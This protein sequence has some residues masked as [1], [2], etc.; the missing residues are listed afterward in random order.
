MRCELERGVE[1]HLE[2]GE[3]AIVDADEVG[4]GRDRNIEFA[5]IVHFDQRGKPPAR[6]AGAEIANLL[7]AQD[8]GDEQDGIG[9]VR[10]GF[11]DLRFGDGEVLAQDR[12]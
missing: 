7:F 6:G 9:P 3:V 4:A 8:G 2:G 10:R 11:E 12:E 1:G 5:A